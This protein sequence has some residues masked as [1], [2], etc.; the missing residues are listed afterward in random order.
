MTILKPTLPRCQG[1]G[2]EHVQ[3]RKCIA[4]G[5]DRWI[6]TVAGFLVIKGRYFMKQPSCILSSMGG[7]YRQCSGC[8][9]TG[10][11]AAASPVISDTEETQ[12]EVAL[13]S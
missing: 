13:K 2:T 6:A 3:W 12:A 10:A 4:S 7:F 11:A 9:R 8:F 5:W 1:L